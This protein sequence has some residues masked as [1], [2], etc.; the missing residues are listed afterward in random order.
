MK[1]IK[2][3]NE[4]RNKK[5]KFSKKALDKIKQNIENDDELSRMQMDMLYDFVVTFDGMWMP[6][7]TMKA[8]D[9]D[10]NEWIYDNMDDILN[11][12]ENKADL[13]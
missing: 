6:Y 9:G 5:I 12:I 11:T 2:E 3:L 8:R 4:A 10:P 13:V 1:L 7:G